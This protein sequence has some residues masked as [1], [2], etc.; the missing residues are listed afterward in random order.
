MKIHP[1]RIDIDLDARTNSCARLNKILA[2]LINLYGQ[3]KS[4][5]WNVRGIQFYSLHLVF[6]NISDDIVEYI[7]SVAERITS[8]GGTAYGT[9]PYIVPTTTLP[10]VDIESYSPVMYLNSMAESITT[11]TQFIRESSV[12]INGDGGISN[13]ICTANYLMDLATKLD[14]NLYFIEAHIEV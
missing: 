7:D 11:I 3:M 13:D 9:L 14:H 8:L 2:D 1:S 12:E 10:V 6:D 4:C 5:H